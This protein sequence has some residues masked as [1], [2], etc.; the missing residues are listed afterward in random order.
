VFRHLVG[1]D[2]F[3]HTE[4]QTDAINALLGRLYPDDPVT[5]DQVC[6]SVIRH[7]EPDQSKPDQSRPAPSRARVVRLFSFV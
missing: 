2:V 5:R 7:I 3:D 1:E 6:M 4:R